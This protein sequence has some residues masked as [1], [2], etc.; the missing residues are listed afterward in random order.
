M[1]TN[2]TVP[3]SSSLI[4]SPLVIALTTTTTQNLFKDLRINK[5]KLL[6][7]FVPD[8]VYNDA[9]LR[10]EPRSNSFY[11]VPA[12]QL[13]ASASS[14]WPAIIEQRCVKKGVSNSYTNTNLSELPF[15]I[16]LGG[17]NVGAVL[18]VS[19][20]GILTDGPDL[21]NGPASTGMTPGH[22][23]AVKLDG[24]NFIPIGRNAITV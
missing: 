17:L 20:A 3:A 14:G 15:G 19:Y 10:F 23:Y 21:N 6:N 9:S 4:W 22:V 13:C 11:S 2:A 5:I 16:Q 18:E 24:D 7:N 12:L 8:S 1:H